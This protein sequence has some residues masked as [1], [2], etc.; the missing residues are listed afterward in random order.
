M[1]SAHPEGGSTWPSEN[2]RRAGPLLSALE[3]T[4]SFA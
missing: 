3:Q 4:S 1:L 2:G